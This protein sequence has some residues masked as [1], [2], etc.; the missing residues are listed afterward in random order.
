MSSHQPSK[1]SPVPTLT[2]RHVLAM[3]V[4]AFLIVIAVNAVFVTYA[5]KTWSGLSVDQ[6]YDRGIKY[7][8]VLEV[9]RAELALGW[10]V[11][12][13]F[14]GRHVTVDL[15]DRDGKAVNG[16][17]VVASL[18]RP[19]SEGY[20]QDLPLAAEGDGRYGTDARVSLPGQWDLRVVAA[21]GPDHF[22]W[23]TRVIVPEAMTKGP[24]P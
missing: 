8:Q 17:K 19:T 22:H 4:G 12:G 3:L 6:P 7:N 14:D 9:D 23:R 11:A 20:D 15:S 10:K 18:E 16:A 13:R 5:L 2:G 24:Q 21:R 1:W